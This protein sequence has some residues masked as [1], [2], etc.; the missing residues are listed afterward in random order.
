M[1]ESKAKPEKAEKAES[2]AKPVYVLAK[3]HGV[4][5]GYT[6]KHYPKGSEFDPE[7]DAVLIS[8]LFK[9]GAALELKE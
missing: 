9:S 4:I 1:A 8:A 6:H 5:E 3:G 2:K 7:K